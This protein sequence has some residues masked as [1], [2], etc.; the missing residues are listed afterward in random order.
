MICDL[1]KLIYQKNYW[2][3]LKVYKWSLDV[4]DFGDVKLVVPFFYDFLKSARIDVYISQD[5]ANVQLNV[6]LRTIADEAS[7][8][9]L[10]E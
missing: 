1:Y 8:L 3:R 5:L 4:G 7:N 10:V 6:A 2:L 9:L